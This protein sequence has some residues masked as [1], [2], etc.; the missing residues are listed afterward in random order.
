M[1]RPM[2]GERVFMKGDDEEGVEGVVTNITLNHVIKGFGC[3]VAWDSG[4]VEIVDPDE[5]ELIQ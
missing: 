5:L 2:P 4:I 3:E 1:A